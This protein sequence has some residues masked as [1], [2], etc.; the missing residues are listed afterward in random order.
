[1]VDEEVGV[2]LCYTGVLLT[3]SLETVAEDKDAERKE[4]EDADDGEGSDL[5]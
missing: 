5:N 4:D 3:P 1:M 2:A